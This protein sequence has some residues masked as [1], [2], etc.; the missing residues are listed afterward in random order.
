MDNFFRI[1]DVND[2]DKIF[3]FGNLAKLFDHLSGCVVDFSESIFD[4]EALNASDKILN[5]EVSRV[6]FIVGL[7]I[8]TDI[9]MESLK[10]IT[11]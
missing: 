8:I 2:S 3:V 9:S 11:G 4:S 6:G 5:L 10:N 1:F 7:V